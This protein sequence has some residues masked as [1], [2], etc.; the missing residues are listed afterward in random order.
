VL[1]QM[2]TRALLQVSGYLP[3][4][5]AYSWLSRCDGT[6]VHVAC[7]QTLLCTCRRVSTTFQRATPP[8]MC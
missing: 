8:G 3:L 6:F 2:L 1:V 5:C 4:W 7:T